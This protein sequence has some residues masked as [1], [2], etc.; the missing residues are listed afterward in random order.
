MSTNFVSVEHI[1]DTAFLTAFYRAMESERPDAHVQ[2]PYARILAGARGE[3]L[4]K[5]IP[6]RDLVAKGCAVR[7]CII[8]G[9]ILEGVEKNG[10]D[11]VLNLGAGLDTRPYRL[12]LPNSLHWIESDLPIVL[13][14]KADKLTNV[15]PVCVLESVP[16]DV[17]DVIT[18]Q[19]VFERIGQITKQVLVVTE[20]LLIYMTR[21]QVADLAMALHAQ[22]QFRWWFTD[23]SSPIGLQQ[24]Q[25]NLGKTLTTGDVKMQFAPEEGTEFFRQYGWEAV[26]FRSF[27]EEAQR[28]KRGELSEEYISQLSQENWKILRQMSGFVLLKRVE[29]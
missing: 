24:I 14:Y 18:R 16:F 22:P 10:V 2:D 29:V 6:D 4:A 13:A 21:E 11:T 23:L 1:S 5:V 12:S 27:F 3:Q 8:D 17:T 20:G 28:L 9:L 25:K 19:M 15:Q 26:E 7:T